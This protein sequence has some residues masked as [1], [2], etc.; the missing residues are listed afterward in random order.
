[1]TS[2]A[3]TAATVCNQFLSN[4]ATAITD[5][6][7]RPTHDYSVYG[8]SYLYLHTRGG[9][10]LPYAPGGIGMISVAKYL[11]QQ[12]YI[13]GQNESHG[14]YEIHINTGGKSYTYTDDE[15]HTYTEWRVTPGWTK[16]AL[17]KAPTQLRDACKG[18][19]RH[20][21][22]YESTLIAK[23]KHRMEVTRT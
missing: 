18:Y 23:A 2:P 17:A 22:D 3:A 6:T 16:I 1:M 13:A 9:A 14:V 7:L 12:P 10:L 15:P 21:T 4:I 8:E 19:H 11:A 20:K 5:R